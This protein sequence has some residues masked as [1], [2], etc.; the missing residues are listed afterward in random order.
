MKMHDNLAREIVYI[1]NGTISLK[2]NPAIL[3]FQN[4][5]IIMSRCNFFL[6]Y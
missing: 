2:K 3:G 4:K 6:F 1:Q 5:W